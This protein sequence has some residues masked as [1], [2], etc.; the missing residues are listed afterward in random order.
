MND[1]LLEIQNYIKKKEYDAYIVLTC[2][3]HGSEYVLDHFKIREFLSGFTGSDGTLVITQNEAYLWTDGRYFIQATNQ[4]SGTGIKLMKSGMSKVPTIAQFIA[5]LSKDPKIC[6]DFR[7]TPISFVNEIKKDNPTV[8][9]YDNENI[10]NKVWKERPEIVLSE[11]YSLSLTNAGESAGDKIDKINKLAK[12]KNAKYTLISALDDVAWTLNLRGNDIPYSPVNYAYLLISERKKFLYINQSKLKAKASSNIKSLGIE[13]KDY[14]AI[15]EDI[16]EIDDQILIDEKKI[17]FK[18]FKSIK[19][20]ILTDKFPSTILKAIKNETEIKNIKK[21]QI[22]DALA[23]VKFMNWLKKSVGKIELDELSVTEKLLEFRKESKNFLD[24]SFDTICGYNSNG[25]IVHYKA[26]EKTN[27][28]I[29]K[30]GLLLIDSGAQYKYA[31]TDITRTF[32][33]GAIS[34]EMKRD[35]TLALKSHIAYATAIIPKGTNGYA[36][37]IIAR[38]PLYKAFKDYRHGTGHGVGYLLNCHEGPQSVTASTIRGACEI[39]PGMVISNEP[40]IYIEHNYG[41]RHENLVLCK[42][43]L[44]NEFNEFYGFET[45]TYVPFDLQGIDKTLL[46]KEEKQWINAYHKDIYN[47]LSKLLSDADRKYLQKITR[48][49]I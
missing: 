29:Q 36:L 20:P 31:T 14:D 30:K 24:L 26:T 38:E 3:D 39:E 15:Y 49:I 40:G 48:A 23:I 43:F 13:I 8:K 11:A 44:K 1:A 25:A 19:N 5:K 12:K 45:L 9:F 28:K 6:T 46:T 7:L 22:E 42:K 47:K 4:L 21:A 10:I 35:F 17:N 18:L 37:D 33:M 41:I 34:D 32:V 16:K 27:K 2:D